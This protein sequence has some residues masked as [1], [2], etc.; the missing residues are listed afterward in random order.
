V[1][2]FPCR[3]FGLARVAAVWDDQ[4]GAAV[5]AHY[6]EPGVSVND[7]LVVGEYRYTSP[8]P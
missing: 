4:A 3:E 6:D 5:A 2:F 1:F 8:T 7:D